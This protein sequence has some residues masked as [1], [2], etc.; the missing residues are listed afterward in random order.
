MDI[1]LCLFDFEKNEVEYAG[2]N[3]PLY[4]VK[5]NELQVTKA[6]K[7]PIGRYDY[8]KPFSN[9][10]INLDGVDNIYMCSDGIQDQ[11]GGSKGKKFKIRRLKRLLVELSQHDINQQKGMLRETFFDWKQGEEQ[12]DDVCFIGIQLK[13]F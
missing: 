4:M 5:G 2:A 1:A 9:H 13:I 6:D 12:V 11:F 3:I 7:Q 8:R 10:I